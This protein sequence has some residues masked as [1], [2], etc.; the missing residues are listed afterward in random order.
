VTTSP[1]EVRRLLAEHAIRPSKTLGQNFVVDPNTLERMVRLADIKSGT[2]VVEVGAG[3]GSL[4]VALADAG[5][6]VLA[7]EV[8]RRLV[9]LLGT[10]VAGRSVRVVQA[11]ALSVRW[12]ELLGDQARWVLVA[13]LPYR[14]ATPVVIR[15]LE[16]AAS[17]QRLVVMVQRE[18]GERWVAS[19][20]DPLYGAISVKIAYWAQAQI[21]GRVPPSVFVPRPKVESVVVRIARR[22]RPAVDPAVVDYRRLCAV[23]GAGFA[24][25]RKMLR[26]SLGA[27]VT[28]EAFAGA[29]VKPSARAE[30]LDVADWGALARLEGS[31]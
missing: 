24:H 14:V 31:R 16:E 28:P 12:E 1:S 5:A 15:V 18:V 29:D 20:G 6:E 11:D 19:V 10:V 4:T 23:V 25:R 26:R 30:E 21:L 7:I 13:N 9:E 22:S 17:V 27:L 2:P 8:D 3:L